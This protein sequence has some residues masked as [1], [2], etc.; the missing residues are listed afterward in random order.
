MLICVGFTYRDCIDY[1]L[2]YSAL[3]SITA[4]VQKPDF[5]NEALSPKATSFNTNFAEDLK[6][7]FQHR[8]SLAAYRHYHT[9]PF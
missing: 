7:I 2:R 3:L 4:S 8:T 1:S 5:H 6:V 9:K